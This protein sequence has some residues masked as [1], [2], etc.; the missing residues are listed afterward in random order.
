MRD[1][2]SRETDLA[3]NIPLDW[4]KQHNTITN[5]MMNLNRSSLNIYSSLVSADRQRVFTGCSPHWLVTIPCSLPV[6]VL[7]S[8]HSHQQIILWQRAGDPVELVECGHR[9]MFHRDGNV[10]TTAAQ[11]ARFRCS[12]RRQIGEFQGPNIRWPDQKILGS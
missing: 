2:L 3:D 12:S 11:G 8:S 4:V 7:Q 10:G 6:C 1:Q 9:H 5:T